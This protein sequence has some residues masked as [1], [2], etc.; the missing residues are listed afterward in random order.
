MRVSV[1]VLSSVAVSGI[2]AGCMIDGHCYQSSAQW[3]EPGIFDA[4]GPTATETSPAEPGLPTSGTWVHDL[5]P[6]ATIESVTWLPAAT[7]EH[8]SEP[9]HGLDFR[10]EPVIQL[11]ASRENYGIRPGWPH[12]YP[13]GPSIDIPADPFL[14]VVV[15]EP[16]TPVDVLDEITTFLDRLG[17]G[18]Q[19]HPD[20]LAHLEAH[21]EKHTGVRDRATGNATWKNGHWAPISDL[22]ALD[23][24]IASFQGESRVESRFVGWTEL[25][26]DPQWKI[27]LDQPVRG[28]EIESPIGMIT[29]AV[30]G[31]DVVNAT[32][33]EHYAGEDAALRSAIQN[34]FR[35]ESITV[36]RLGAAKIDQTSD[37]W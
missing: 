22:A 8:F 18:A 36:K 31:S 37:C 20:I 5:W 13:Y 3:T 10:T 29:V 11:F 27:T 23:H 15:T 26:V 16:N 28:L 12:A 4:F 35:N 6:K 24:F 25:M 19:A 21:K 32:S 34:A 30:D 2:F 33:P 1:L 9:G 7:G 14:V 17:I